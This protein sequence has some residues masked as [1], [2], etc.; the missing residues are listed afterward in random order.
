[1][2]YRSLVL[3]KNT[4]AVVAMA[5]VLS[6]GRVALAQSEGQNAADR[7]RQTR[8]TELKAKIANL[9]DQLK[10]TESEGKS[11]N[12]GVNHGATS[13]SPGCCGG[14]GSGQTSS[15]THLHHHP[16]GA[17]AQAGGGEPSPGGEHPMG[18]GTGGM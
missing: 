6:F 17:M 7:A 13:K 15:S 2:R 5:V 8:I 1:M 18:G 3:G 16:A 12:P 10:K 4:L 9:Q 14:A 11:T